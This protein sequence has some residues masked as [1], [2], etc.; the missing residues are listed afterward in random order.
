MPALVRAALLC[1][2]NLSSRL[3]CRAP[4][5]PTQGRRKKLKPRATKKPQ[6]PYLSNITAPTIFLLFPTLSNVS[7]RLRPS[8]LK[9]IQYRNILSH[10]KDIPNSTLASQQTYSLREK[11]KKQYSWSST[12]TRGRKDHQMRQKA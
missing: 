2:R 3:Q 10:G 5:S 9:S 7:L 11:K 6:T 12:V 4:H 1:M 8:I